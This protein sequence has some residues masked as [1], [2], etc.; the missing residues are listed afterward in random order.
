LPWPLSGCNDNCLSG[1]ASYVGEPRVPIFY[2]EYEPGEKDL[3]RLLAEATRILL[4]LSPITA[5]RPAKPH[6]AGRTNSSKTTN[7][8]TGIPAHS[9][10]ILPSSPRKAVPLR[11]FIFTPAGSFR[12]A[13]LLIAP[14]PAGTASF[15]GL[16]QTT[17][18]LFFRTLLWSRGVMFKIARTW[19]GG[20]QVTSKCLFPTCRVLHLF[21]TITQFSVAEFGY[22]RFER[23]D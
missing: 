21:S 23:P 17:D 11:G 6:N 18:V 12:L 20:G 2:I 15:R 7:A 1:F 13:L 16:R 19:R 5:R 22:A 8:N 9:N 10:T 3:A 4:R 14:I